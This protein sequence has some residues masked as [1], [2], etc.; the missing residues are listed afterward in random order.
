MDSGFDLEEIR[1]ICEGKVK[2]VLAE[3]DAILSSIKNLI[4]YSKE[5]TQ[6][7]TI[8]SHIRLELTP[9]NPTI[10][11]LG[12]SAIMRHNL[13]FIVHMIMK[14]I[15]YDRNKLFTYFISKLTKKI[16]RKDFS[17]AI[18]KDVSNFS[19]PIDKDWER[20]TAVFNIMYDEFS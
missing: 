14:N 19:I 17:G 7:T 13:N 8:R 10:A 20:N 9:S 2:E 6:M 18:F 15:D 3:E 5:A 11:G 16:L 1:K 4:I 12:P